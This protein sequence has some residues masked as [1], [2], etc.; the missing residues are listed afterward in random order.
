MIS[1]VNPPNLQPPRY[2]TTAAGAAQAPFFGTAAR[3]DMRDSLVSEAATREYQT[4]FE[5]AMVD[6]GNYVLKAF[7]AKV[8]GDDGEGASISFDS[9]SI[10][11]DATVSAAD[12]IGSDGVHGNAIHS[13]YAQHFTGKGT[14]T[15]ADGRKLDFDIDIQRAVEIHVESIDGA[16]P[17]AQPGPLGSSTFRLPDFSFPGYLADLLRLIGV[18]YKGVIVGQDGQSAAVKMRMVHVENHVAG[19]TYSAAPLATPE[20]REPAKGLWTGSS[21]SIDMHI[22]D[23]AVAAQAENDIELTRDIFGGTIP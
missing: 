23:T 8:L 3:P 19:E 20:M 17:P 14:V 22:G 12:W 1:I 21:S 15:T 16:D 10:G 4:A 9:S 18:E 5:N 2:A 13:S 7:A 6:L 11:G